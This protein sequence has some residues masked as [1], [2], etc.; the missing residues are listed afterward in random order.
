[1][2]GPSGQ[3]RPRLRVTAPVVELRDT[4]V[5]QTQGAPMSMDSRL[6]GKDWL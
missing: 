5:L 4:W 3:G 6:R 1:M 2:A